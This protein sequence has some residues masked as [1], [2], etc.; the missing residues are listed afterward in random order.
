MGVARVAAHVVGLLGQLLLAQGV[1]HIEL[2]GEDRILGVAAAGELDLHDDLTVGH[3]HRHAAEEGLEVLWQLL[4]AGVARVHRDEEADLLVEIHGRA[5]GELEGLHVHLDRGE[6]IRHLLGGHREH[7]EVDPVELVEAAPH[8]GHGQPLVDAA[9]RAVVHLVG[10]VGHHD[11]LAER[12]AHVLGRLG[13][14]RAR[15]AGG[16][17]AEEHAEGLRE[18]DVAAVGEGR[19]DEPLLDAEVL[20]VVLEVDVGDGDLG[21]VE[22]VPPVEAR[23]LLPLKVLGVLDPLLLDFLEDILLVDVDE[24]HGLHLAASP[25]AKLAQVHVRPHI[26][27]DQLVQP[28]EVLLDGRLHDALLRFGAEQRVLGVE[29]PL[30]LDPNERHLRLVLVCKVLGAERLALDGGHADDLVERVL[31]LLE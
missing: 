5:V 22:V 29:G 11:V 1:E 3:H 20:V 9:E 17:A 23:L 6:H 28:L 31:H 4:P 25:L 21:V 13:L 16:R 2:L 10:A 15:G 19:D 8:A 26:D 18:R 14:A 27:P 12:A 30:E 7:L 24:D